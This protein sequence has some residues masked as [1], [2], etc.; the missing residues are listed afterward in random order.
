MMLCRNPYMASG[1]Q[2]FGCGQCMPC[3]VN[4]RRMWT[5]RIMLEANLHPV[6]S[7]VTLT[8]SDDQIPYT[9][10]ALQTL[11]RKDLTDFL[12][13]L[14]WDYQPSQLR[15][16]S[17]GEYGDQTER[18]H[19]HLA[20]F[21]YPPCARGVTRI[22][23]RQDCCDIC[24]RIA[25]IWGQGIIHSGQLE[26]SSAAYISGYVTKKF[27]SPKD[28]RLQGRKEEFATMSLKPGIG[29]GFMDEV[30]STLLEHSLDQL[31]D[32]PNALAHGGRPRPLGRYL[33]RRL[34][35]RIGSSPDAP[36][37]TLQANKDR[38]QPMRDHAAKI[39]P[40]QGFTNAF[41]STIIDAHEGQYQRL[42][43]RTNLTKKRGSI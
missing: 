40:V 29:A 16:F 33:T 22:N 2:A 5:H 18:P 38:L 41:K 8:Y 4:R 10:G 7:F 35:E 25:R 28:P 27:T 32:V 31:P 13:R 24:V 15:Y 6:N 34:R 9:Q 14:R 23:G 21:N 42:V 30:A 11:N 17:V 20:L 36:Q 1:G 19:Y 12:K 3:R 37:S 43:A 26:S 39:A